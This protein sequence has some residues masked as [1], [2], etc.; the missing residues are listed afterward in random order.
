MYLEQHSVDELPESYCQVFLR[1]SGIDNKSI[2]DIIIKA[3]EGV[4]Y[5]LNLSVD[6]YE[7]IKVYKKREPTPEDFGKTQPE[8][9]NTF[10]KYLG[11]NEI[12]ALEILSAPNFWDHNLFYII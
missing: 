2:Q 9:F 7:K 3:S 1:E 12:R 11:C 10:V 4:P 5:Y 8:I 6:I